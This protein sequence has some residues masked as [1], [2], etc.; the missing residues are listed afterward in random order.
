MLLD[1]Y[2]QYPCIC[3]ETVDPEPQAT[4][5]EKSDQS[6]AVICLTSICPLYHHFQ[7]DFLAHIHYLYDY[8][9]S[10]RWKYC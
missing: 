2:F 3:G 6:W 9:T 8:Q 4:Y 7:P 5:P 10:E 1:I